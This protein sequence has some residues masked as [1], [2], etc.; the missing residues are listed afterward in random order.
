MNQYAIYENGRP[1]HRVN[2]ENFNEV[3]AKLDEKYKSRD[4]GQKILLL[5]FTE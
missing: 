3:L 1:T 2:A 4:F 5:E